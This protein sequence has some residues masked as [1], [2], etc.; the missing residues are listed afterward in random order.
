VRNWGCFQKDASYDL[1]AGLIR[2]DEALK[3]DAYAL[4]RVEMEN[5]E[6]SEN[7]DVLTGMPFLWEINTLVARCSL[8]VP[9]YRQR[10]M[11]FF[12]DTDHYI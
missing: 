7:S 2:S 10:Y 12:Q 11:A 8:A 4:L 5:W 6:D 1:L 3:K 9:D